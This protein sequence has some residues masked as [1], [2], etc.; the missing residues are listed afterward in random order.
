[1]KQNNK[2]KLLRTSNNITQ[3]YLANMLHMSISCYSR[4]ELGLRNF[5]IKEAGEIAS[6]FNTTIE[7]IFLE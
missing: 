1:M 7:K 4:K 3:K 5:T 2:L 6:F